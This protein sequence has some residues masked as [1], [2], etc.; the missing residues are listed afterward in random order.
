MKTTTA[1]PSSTLSRKWLREASMRRLSSQVKNKTQTIDSASK[2]QLNIDKLEDGL[3]ESGLNAF[4]IQQL[5]DWVNGLLT[6]RQCMLAILDS[7]QN[8]MNSK[9]STANFSLHSPLLGSKGK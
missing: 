6:G 7:Y 1:S 3:E 8:E 5:N 9:F 4:I 2:L